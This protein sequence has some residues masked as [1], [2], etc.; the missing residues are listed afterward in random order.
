M[1]VR[2]ALLPTL[3]GPLLVTAT[4]A[5][6]RHLRVLPES[7]DYRP[8]LARLWPADLPEVALR[9]D[10][11]HF[12][13]LARQL[14]EY[15]GGLRR[16]FDLPL[17]PVGS[18]FQ[19]EVW[20]RVGKIPFGQLT[21]FREL[22]N[23]VGSPEGARAVGQ[24]VAQNPLA[25]LIPSHRVVGVAGRLKGFLA[26]ND[27]KARLLRLEGHTLNGAEQVKPPQLF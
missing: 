16:G 11:R 6:M 13:P 9:E 17:D 25:L 19:L 24:A 15:F 1:I 8:E 23:A 22:A 12:L 3:A 20:Q 5:G 4:D 21:T 18:R 27:L 14:G 2:H 10:P 26:G 7:H